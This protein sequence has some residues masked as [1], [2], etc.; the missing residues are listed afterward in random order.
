[1]QKTAETS[2]TLPAKKILLRNFKNMMIEN[3]YSESTQ[4]SYLRF[5]E[6]FLKENPHPSRLDRYDV[7]RFILTWRNRL[8][9]NSMKLATSAL[10]KFYKYLKFFHG[11]R[12]ADS[13]INHIKDLKSEFFRTRP[14]KPDPMNEDE[15]VTLF[16]YTLGDN[17]RSIRRRCIITILL[18]TGLRV[19]EFCAINREQVTLHEPG[20]PSNI[21]IPG[22][23]TPSARRKIPLHRDFPYANQWILGERVVEAFDRYQAARP[24]PK[25]RQEDEYWFLSERGTRISKRSVQSMFTRLCAKAGLQEKRKERGEETLS[26]HNLR[27]TF[28]TQ[29]AMQGA[30]A[31]QIKAILGHASVATSQ[32]YIRLLESIG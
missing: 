15:L 19:S 23:K 26:V 31:Y 11:Y 27:H 3:E 9:K 28:A 25:N 22:G 21:F 24:Q 13:V 30:N 10:I 17:A 29:L 7:G 4:Q 14:F 16:Q 20:V 12:D 2:A 1:M 6:P 8:S 5:V 32:A 18:G